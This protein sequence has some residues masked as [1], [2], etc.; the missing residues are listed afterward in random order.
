MLNFA[1]K[2]KLKVFIYAGDYDVDK[3]Q[4]I[5]SINIIKKYLT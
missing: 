3:S 4:L 1:D 2:N 5:E